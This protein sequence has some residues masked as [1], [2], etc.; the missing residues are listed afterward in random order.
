MSNQ[1]FVNIKDHPRYE[2]NKDGVIR[3]KQNKKVKAQYVGSTGYYMVS[4]SYKNK[5]NPHRV[6]RL[7]ATTFI[8][9]PLNAPHVNHIDGDKLNNKLSNLEWV[10][11]AE[12]MKHAFDN[13]LA[14]N[15]GEN[16]GQSKLTEKQVIEIKTL[17]N[18]GNLSQYKI[19]KLYGV[20]RSCV[21]G[22]NTGRLWQHIKD[23][24]TQR[25]DLLPNEQE[26]VV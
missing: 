4:F 1:E 23:V 12:N 8:K 10:T 18:N 2:I 25:Q 24:S 5:S 13:K 20:S 14:N 26:S 7:L 17:L 21:L 16:N 11:H 19:A 9:N 15:T 22:I 6:H 3:N